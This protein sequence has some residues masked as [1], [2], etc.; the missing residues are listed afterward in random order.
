[1]AC[2]HKFALRPMDFAGSI[3]WVTIRRIPTMLSKIPMAHVTYTLCTS[4][5]FWDQ[6]GMRR[7]QLGRQNI[8]D[9]N[10]GLTWWSETLQAILS[11]QYL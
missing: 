9:T 4:I 11:E 8:K 6:I 10:C 1:M 2:S 3:Y 7:A 5:D